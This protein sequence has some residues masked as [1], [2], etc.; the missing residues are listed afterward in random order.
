M[1]TGDMPDL[2]HFGADVFAQQWSSEGL[3][4]D[5]TD[6][7]GNYKNLSENITAE[8]YGD[9][10]FL[11][12]GRIY[13]FPKPNSYD[14]WGY[15]VNQKWLDTLGLSAPRTIEEY[16]NVS[17]AFT[18]NDPDGDGVANTFGG[19][20]HT[21]LWHLKN[22]FVS[23]AYSISGW[24]HGMPDFDH[25]AKLR[26]FK[27]RYG[28]YLKLVRSMYEE[29]ILDREFITHTG[30]ENEEKFAQQRVGFV[31]TSQKGFTGVL[32]KYELNPDDYTYCAP[33]ILNEGEEPT[34]AVPPSNW[35]AYYVNAA[36]KNTDAIMRVLDYGNSEEGFV[37]MQMG[38]AGMHYDN[39]DIEKRTITRTKEQEE[40]VKKA[41]GSMFA[42]A[43][44][45][46]GRP[47]TEGGSNPD[48]IAKWQREAPA[49][50][51]ITVKCY[52]GF[53]KMID[54]ISV[55]YPDDSAALNTLEVRYIT[56]EVSFEELMDFINGDYKN[57]CAAVAQELV[58]YMAAN[59]PRYVK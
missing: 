45:Y 1:A 31:G 59:P 50:D 28:D 56:G 7:I 8:Q 40:A 29:G 14:M 3:F 13:G 37:L 22:D 18:L 39:Y 48:A 47:P 11:P 41:T 57:K 2:L 58:D 9:C 21:G 25:S 26:P 46:K 32:T 4:L 35:M 5:V 30:D 23:I 24:H 42:F 12:D 10:I 6:L 36:S 16:V 20:L 27:S 55:E 51:A 54:K 38:I 19:G 15:L 43:N 34:Y 33:L 52:F 17:R 44:A 53:T 49:V